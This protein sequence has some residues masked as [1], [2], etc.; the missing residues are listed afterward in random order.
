VKHE[1]VVSLH[2]YYWLTVVL[3]DDED[4]DDDDD[5]WW[6]YNGWCRYGS[7]SACGFGSCAR[8]HTTSVASA[9]FGIDQ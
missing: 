8:T 6:W 5:D 7:N 2:C 1:R 4:D 9:L 3:N